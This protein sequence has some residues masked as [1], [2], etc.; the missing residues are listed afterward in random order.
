MSPKFFVY[1][2]CV[3][4]GIF[5]ANINTILILRK[6]CPGFYK[7]WR[8]SGN[9]NSSKNKSGIQ[10]RQSIHSHSTEQDDQASQKSTGFLVADRMTE[11]IP[12]TYI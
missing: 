9:P 7:N 1:N 3:F 12:S 4:I 8:R 2:G 5:A 6:A 10:L 11:I